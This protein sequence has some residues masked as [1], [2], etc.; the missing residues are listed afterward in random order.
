MVTVFP[1]DNKLESIFWILCQIGADSK[2]EGDTPISTITRSV[3]EL[4]NENW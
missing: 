2:L 4:L 1:P 3:E